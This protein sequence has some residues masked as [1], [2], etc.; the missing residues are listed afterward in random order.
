MPSTRR[1]YDDTNTFCFILAPLM[2][3]LLRVVN[4][5]TGLLIYDTHIIFFP[6]RDRFMQ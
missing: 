5:W 3:G 2:L 6:A 4:E 1:F